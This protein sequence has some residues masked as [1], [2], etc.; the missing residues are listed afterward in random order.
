MTLSQRRRAIQATHSPVATRPR[1]TGVFRPHATPRRLLERAI[2]GNLLPLKRGYPGFFPKPCPPAYDSSPSIG[3]FRHS[4]ADRCARD[5]TVF[6]TDMVW[7]DYWDG[8][9]TD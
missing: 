6:G 5:A 7:R 1:R 3:R 4:R 2:G 8:R 9:L